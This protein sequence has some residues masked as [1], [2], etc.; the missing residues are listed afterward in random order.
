MWFSKSTGLTIPSASVPASTVVDHFNPVGNG[1]ACGITGL[2]A[3]PVVELGLKCR[4][5]RLSHRIIETHP[6]TPHGLSNAQVAAHLPE[7]L[8]GKLCSPVSVKH[9]T[10]SNV[11]AEA[12]APSAVLIRPGMYLERYP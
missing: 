5:E 2:P 4:P 3:L 8:A 6:S 9:E 12:Y 7:L 10:I 11:T 1:L